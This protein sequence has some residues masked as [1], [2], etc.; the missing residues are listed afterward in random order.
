MNMGASPLDVDNTGTSHPDVENR[1]ITRREMVQRQAVKTNVG[2]IK[3]ILIIDNNAHRYVEYLKE[4]TGIEDILVCES[5]ASLQ[6]QVQGDCP[7]A[8]LAYKLPEGRFPREMLVN[9]PVIKW[10]QLGSAGVDHISPWDP[11][12]LVVTNSSGVHGPH[13]SQYVLAAMLSHNQ[14]LMTYL[15]QKERRLW[16]RHDAT[17]LSN[18][19][20]VVV[21]FGRIGRAV[22]EACRKQGME[23]IGVN[24]TGRRVPEA[25]CIVPARELASAVVDA[26]HVVITLPLTSETRGIVDQTVFEKMSPECFFIDVSRGG[27]VDAKCLLKYLKEGKIAGAALDVFEEEPLSDSDPL[28]TL[29]NVI[30]TPHNSGDVD[31]WLDRVAEMFAR[32]VSR[33]NA[34]LPLDNVVDPIRGY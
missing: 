17:L 18:Q 28:W 21:G 2:S 31:G 15:S 29:P 14:R 26:H 9:N 22:G 30:I 6:R 33:N 3:R 11:Q 24:T 32:N 10:I 19:K 13:I 34:G 12:K 8:V 25:S 5:Y 4:M 16:L 7:E 27:V 1:S 23:V 20:V